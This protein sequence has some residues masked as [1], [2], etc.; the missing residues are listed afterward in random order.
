MSG[1]RRICIA[2]VLA[3]SAADS[4]GAEPIPPEMVGIW[5]TEDAVMRGTLLFEGQA[6]YLGV[7]GVAAW[8]A[9]PPPIGVQMQCSYEPQLSTVNCITIETDGRGHSGRIPY[10]ATSNRFVVDDRPLIRRFDEFDDKSRRAL[11][12]SP[13]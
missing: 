5:A 6:L 11:G 7:D 9:G 13:N 8:I 1:A 4:V 2:I 10:D 3:V 12:V